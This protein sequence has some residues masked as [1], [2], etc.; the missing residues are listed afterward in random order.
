[1][2]V[3]PW[4]SNHSDSWPSSGTAPVARSLAGWRC[5]FRRLFAWGTTSLLAIAC[6]AVHHIKAST[7]RP[8]LSH[9]IYNE[10]ACKHTRVQMDVWALLPCGECTIR[11]NYVLTMNPRSY[12]TRPNTRY[13]V[14]LSAAQVRADDSAEAE[15]RATLADRSTTCQ[16]SSHVP[17]KQ[18]HGKQATTCHASGLIWERQATHHRNKLFD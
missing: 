17:T 11:A 6:S 9:K 2:L 18:Q 8:P 1:M 5:P 16:P 15:A 3:L 13:F 10:I 14:L 7:S 12:A 4:C